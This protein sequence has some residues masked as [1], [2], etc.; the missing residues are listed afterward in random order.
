MSAGRFSLFAAILATYLVAGILYITFTPAWQAPDEPAHFNYVRYLTTNAGFP[1]LTS[2]CYNQAY[3]DQLKSQNFPPEL[4]VDN[5]CYE[6]HQPPLYY[7]LATPVFVLS[8]GSI[9][10]LRLFSLLLGAGVVILAFFT[11]KTIFPGSPSLAFGTMAFVAFVPMH[12]AILSSINNDALAELIL[13]AIL[14]ALARRIMQTNLRTTRA[15]LF[16]GALLGIG[17]I[18]KTTVYIAVP[19]IAV[20]LLLIEFPRQNESIFKINWRRLFKHAAIIYGL[21]LLIAL[22]WYIRNTNLYGN[23]D[24]LGLTRH[25]EIVIGQD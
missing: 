15:S 17:L 20:A 10:A 16:I 5:V 18:T 1:E 6:Y 14:F 8:S 12:V 23:L 7:V 2:G 13:A 19:V 11:G 25:D 9:I 24:I 3:L 22:P 4:P 21:A